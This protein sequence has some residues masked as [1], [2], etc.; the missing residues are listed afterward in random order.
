MIYEFRTYAITPGRHDVQHRRFGAENLPLFARHGL[1]LLGRWTMHAVQD[2]PCF[3]YIMGFRDLAEREAQWAN[4]YADPEWP[5]VRA[6]TQRD[7]EAIDKFDVDFLRASP[8]RPDLA[9]SFPAASAGIQE[10]IIADI[11]V[12][13][14]V[15]GNDFL[16]QHYLPALER[17]GARPLIVADYI[18]GQALPRVALLLDW[19]D[20]EA[21]LQGARALIVDQ[22]LYDAI[23]QHRRSHNRAVFARSSAFLLD[24]ALIAFR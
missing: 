4:F 2:G 22:D 13:R 12:G 23:A 16:V 24:P 9:K 21:Q 18:T 5:E 11:P 20:S 8:V 10:L 7:E 15:E 3:F 6:R 14:G 19:Q 17:A 1:T